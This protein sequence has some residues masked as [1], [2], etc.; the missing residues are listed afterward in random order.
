MEWNVSV[1]R[2][3]KKLNH[4]SIENHLNSNF[5]FS[6]VVDKNEN[7]WL[8][9]EKGLDFVRII[10]TSIKYTT[11][12]HWTALKDLKIFKTQLMLTMKIISGLVQSMEL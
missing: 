3:I 10:D 4:F 12:L 11:K 6:L 5:I 8:A 9:N 7:L 2:K 1:F